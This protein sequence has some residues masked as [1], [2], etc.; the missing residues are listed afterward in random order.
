MEITVEKVD[1]GVQKLGFQA[2]S[3]LKTVR[4]AVYA[5][6]S[7]DQEIQLH[8]LE[9]QMKA[10][11]A[12]IAQHPGW[13]LV[14][15]YADEGIS[16]TSVKKRKEFL[17]MMEDCEAGKVDYIMAKVSLDLPATRSNVCPMCAIFRASVSS[18]TLKRKDWIRQRRCPN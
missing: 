18:F 1:T 7:T 6:V 11:R 13:M 4:V 5:R 10:F 17:R 8:S 15:V 9:E 2:L 3:T 14:D 16:G 12:K